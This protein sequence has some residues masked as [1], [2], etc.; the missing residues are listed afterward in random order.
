M[1][2]F[3]RFDAIYTVGLEYARQVLQESPEPVDA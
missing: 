2:D 3:K 1:F